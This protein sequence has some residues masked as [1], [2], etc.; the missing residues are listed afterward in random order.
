MRGLRAQ[1]YRDNSDPL[2]L[3]LLLYLSFCLI[4]INFLD[5]D[6]VWE[7]T[8]MQLRERSHIRFTEGDWVG[9]LQ[10]EALPLPEAGVRGE[11][12][13]CL[14]CLLLWL[15]LFPFLFLTG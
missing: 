10:R 14:R 7:E 9:T 6:G 15:I 8:Q 5:R 12:G 3:T 13:Y 2:D 1:R 11:W 4:K